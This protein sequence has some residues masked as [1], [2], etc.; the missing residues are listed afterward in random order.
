MRI[1]L[2]L[3]HAEEQ[4]L[5]ATSEVARHVAVAVRCAQVCDEDEEPADGQVVWLTAELG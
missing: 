5:V 2:G 4:V 3:Q 1:C